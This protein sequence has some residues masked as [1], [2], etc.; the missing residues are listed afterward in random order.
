MVHTTVKL[1]KINI[2]SNIF[3]QNTEGDIQ[4]MQLIN[5][6]SIPSSNKKLKF[7]YKN[8]QETQPHKVPQSN[9]PTISSSNYT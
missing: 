2:T 9:Q 7:N 6:K 1:S 5:F 3:E 4:K 8:H